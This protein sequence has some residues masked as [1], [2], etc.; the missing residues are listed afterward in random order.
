MCDVFFKKTKKKQQTYQ[1][2]QSNAVHSITK[3]LCHLDICKC[4]ESTHLHDLCLEK[5][6]QTDREVK[7]E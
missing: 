5:N 6:R 1:T 3:T 2:C 7:E 4:N